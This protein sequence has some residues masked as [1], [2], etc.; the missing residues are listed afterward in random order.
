MNITLLMLHSLFLEITDD[1]TDLINVFQNNSLMAASDN[2][3][4][5]ICRERI[6]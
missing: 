3:L 2:Y 4:K 6:N 5:I 1:E